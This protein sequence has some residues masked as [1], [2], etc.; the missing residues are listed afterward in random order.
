MTEEGIIRLL[1][2][3]HLPSSQEA[4]ILEILK[5]CSFSVPPRCYKDDFMI[6]DVFYFPLKAGCDSIK[7]SS[8]RLL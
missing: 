5:V 7:N 4:E 2:L 3:D 8:E 6:T 1:I